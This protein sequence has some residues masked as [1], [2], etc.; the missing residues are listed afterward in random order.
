VL[1]KEVRPLD[2]VYTGISINYIPYVLANH[3]G[4]ELT[5]SLKVHQ[6]QAKSTSFQTLVYL[7]NSLKQHRGIKPEVIC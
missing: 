7:A 6:N 4:E 5:Y 2:V 3:S 1:T